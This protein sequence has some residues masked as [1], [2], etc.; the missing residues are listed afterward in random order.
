MVFFCSVVGLTFIQLAKNGNAFN[1][2]H[3]YPSAH[4]ALIEKY[5]VDYYSYSTDTEQQIILVLNNI[6]S[7]YN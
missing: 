7:V 4:K 3:E 2:T 1:F 6:T 5:Y